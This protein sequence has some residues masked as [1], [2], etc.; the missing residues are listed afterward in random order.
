MTF[1]RN[2]EFRALV[3]VAWE[4]GARP[5][6]LV[7]ARVRHF[8]AANRRIVFPPGES[9]GGETPRVIYLTDTAFELLRPKS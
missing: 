6:E 7:G 1:I 5:Q 8:D 4:T 3:V 2:D 9:K